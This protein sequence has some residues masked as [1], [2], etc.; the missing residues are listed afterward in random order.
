MLVVALKA[1]AAEVKG[2]ADA[3]LPVLLLRE[4]GLRGELSAVH[5]HPW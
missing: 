2:G 1:A 3:G 5:P 4:L